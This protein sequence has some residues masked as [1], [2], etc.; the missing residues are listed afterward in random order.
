MSLELLVLQCR[1]LGLH[2]LQGLRLDSLHVLLSAVLLLVIQVTL[3]EELHL[4]RGQAQMDDA[5]KD[6]PMRKT[7]GAI[8][9]GS[10]PHDF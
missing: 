4:L 2:I 5:F 7:T 9:S 8:P 3:E 10:L 1:A 6:V